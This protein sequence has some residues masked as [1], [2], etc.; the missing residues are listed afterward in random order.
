MVAILIVIAV[1]AAV[2]IGIAYTAVLWL[3]DIS[4]TL[5]QIR[6]LFA[7]PAQTQT[8]WVPRSPTESALNGVGKSAKMM[9]L[10]GSH[11]QDISRLGKH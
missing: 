1:L 2:E 10:S 7:I 5:S 9:P 3:R 4:R 11:P 8:Q 6:N